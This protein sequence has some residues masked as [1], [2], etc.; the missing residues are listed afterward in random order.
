[1]CS[2]G[3]S[4]VGVLGG[5]RQYLRKGQ[6]MPQ[7]LMLPE[8]TLWQ[9]IRG[10]QP[11]YESDHPTAWKLVDKRIHSRTALPVP[12][13]P[14]VFSARADA[15]TPG[16]GAPPSEAVTADV[17][18]YVK[19]GLPCPS[20]GWWR[21]EESH[22]LDGTRWFAQGSLLP[23]ATFKVPPG[24]FRKTTGHPEVI[25]RRSTWQLVRY[26]PGPAAGVEESKP[27]VLETH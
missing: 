14:A 13:E 17:G 2:E 16:E 27:E 19:T 12:L 26:A 20:S 9:K 5:Q 6:R 25:H 11:S 1:L 10:L 18:S 23:A 4:G 7:A 8:Q 21:C 24:V 15:M 3:G 22:A